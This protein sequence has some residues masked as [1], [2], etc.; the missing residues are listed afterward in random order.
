MTKR[1]IQYVQ[2]ILLITILSLGMLGQLYM[3]EVNSS[4]R[5]LSLSSHIVNNI[6]S[7]NENNVTL[8]I[9]KVKF[10][11]G[12]ILNFSSIDEGL[13]ILY[14]GFKQGKISL[15]DIENITVMQFISWMHFLNQN[16]SSINESY[17]IPGYRLFFSKLNNPEHYNYSGTVIAVSE[18]DFLYN[19]FGEK[20][21][22]GV[23]YGKIPEF[24]IYYNNTS[25]SLK[26]MGYEHYILVYTNASDEEITGAIIDEMDNL[27]AGL[28]AS[29]LSSK[30]YI[31]V[32]DIT[33]SLQKSEVKNEGTSNT[34]LINDCN[35][36][37][38]RGNGTF[39]V[40]GFSR[41]PAYVYITQNLFI[42]RKTIGFESSDEIYR[43]ISTFLAN[44]E[45]SLTAYMI[46]SITACDLVETKRADIFIEVSDGFGLATISIAFTIKDGEENILEMGNRSKEIEDV[47]IYLFEIKLPNKSRLL[48][49]DV[50]IITKYGITISQSV[51][52]EVKP[53]KGP[54]KPEE[55][56][57]W[58]EI[59]T[60][61]LAVLIV[62]SLGVY[63]YRKTTRERI[64]KSRKRR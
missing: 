5:Y 36:S 3:M 25:I 11:N 54:S 7:N 12:T 63:A 45:I 16:I 8:P 37:I 27:M 35:T 62:I 20:F 64:P 46:K 38:E 9:M 34:L 56:F 33:N 22:K 43:Y 40:F 26:D 19:T 47:G 55:K 4:G 10:S 57:P 21:T 18:N 58:L 6:L 49:V 14:N 31:I 39:R 51:S 42:W 17:Y 59:I 52:F 24:R 15:S 48:E 41:Y 32:V 50:K 29:D 1:K 23:L 61:F 28:N 13:S 53:L 2:A 60:A 30:I 44:G